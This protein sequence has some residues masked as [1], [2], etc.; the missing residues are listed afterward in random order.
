LNAARTF[1]DLS[2][3]NSFQTKGKRKRLE[4]P[5]WNRVQVQNLLL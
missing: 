1:R 5:L 3:A 4:R 2:F